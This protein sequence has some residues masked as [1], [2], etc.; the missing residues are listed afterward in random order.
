LLPTNMPPGIVVP[1]PTRGG[2]GTDPVPAGK[3]ATPK[4][5][6]VPNVDYGNRGWKTVPPT[7][8]TLDRIKLRNDDSLDGRALGWEGGVVRW[9]HA[10]V[11]LPIRF[12]GAGITSLKLAPPTNA[13]PSAATGWLV[14]LTNGNLLTGDGLTMNAD[15]VELATSVAGQLRLPRPMVETVQRNSVQGLA[16]F[17][18]LQWLGGWDR[19]NFGRQDQEMNQ[20]R[21][22]YRDVGLPDC[23]GVEL[24]VP[25]RMAPGRSVTLF[26]F[27]GQP[28]R[29]YTDPFYTVSLMDN[30]LTIRL[31]GIWGGMPSQLQLRPAKGRNTI[32][33][34][35]LV[36]RLTGRVVLMVDGEV[37]QTVQLAPLPERSGRGVLVADSLP[38]EP[39]P[40][41]LLLTPLAEDLRLPV[42]KAD[43]VG[44]LLVVVAAG[45]SIGTVGVAVRLVLILALVMAASATTCTVIAQAARAAEED[46]A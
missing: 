46:D 9:E 40:P 7:S 15:T 19:V 24:L 12:Q 2:S 1:Q 28:S 44:L 29:L 37:K 14:R 8:A 20:Q 36:N 34:G 23:V 26:L 25:A 13:P 32:A 11:A 41:W 30:Q 22:V 38:D 18:A 10:A 45:V 5:Q 33:L 4:P 27:C 31:R 3:E 39:V 16:N 21:W 43:T 6:R 35:V 42:A 17:G